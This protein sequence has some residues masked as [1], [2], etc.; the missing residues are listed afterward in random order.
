[1]RE[2]RQ[3]EARE[4]ACRVPLPRQP[5][6]R[7]WARR[8]RRACVALRAPAGSCRARSP[9]VSETHCGGSAPPAAAA[10][11]PEPLQRVRQVDMKRKWC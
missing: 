2:L 7:P 10:A 3:Q 6:A 11:A 8:A 9:F 5:P 4:S 1:M